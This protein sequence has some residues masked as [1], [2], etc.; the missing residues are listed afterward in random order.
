MSNHDNPG[1]HQP[2]RDVSR[3]PIWE[4]TILKRERVASE[5]RLTFNEVNAMAADVREPFTFVPLKPHS[6]VTSVVTVNTESAGLLCVDTGRG[7]ANL[8]V[9]TGS[10]LRQRVARTSGAISYGNPPGY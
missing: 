4:A 6:V 8:G 2:K 3:F 7:A 1:L 9:E 10:Y 5:E